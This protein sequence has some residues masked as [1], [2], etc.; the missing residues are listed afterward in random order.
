MSN[1]Q[2][3][4]VTK[5]DKAQWRFLYDNVKGSNPG[6]MFTFEK[7]SAITGFDRKTNRG[8]VP[9]ANKELLKKHN[10]MLINVRKEGYKMAPATRQLEHAA[11][12]KLR[13]K[14]QLDKG[15]LEAMNIRKEDLS[16]DEKQR[17][18]HLVNHIQISLRSVRK[19]NLDTIKHQEQVIQKQ[20]SGLSQLDIIMAEIEEIK[21][22]IG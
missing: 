6:E 4:F 16:F 21:K 1:V 17:M 14:R 8:F 18:T 2:N 15:L 22:K 3:L 19:R 10:K 13:G 5:A 7:M 11:N 12:R 20:K 9:R